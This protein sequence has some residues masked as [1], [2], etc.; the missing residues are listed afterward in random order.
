M[1]R[2]PGPRRA[3]GSL[4]HPG[5]RAEGGPRS[6]W[7]RCAAGGGCAQDGSSAPGGAASAW[8]ALRRGEPTVRL[9]DRRLC[10]RRG[11]CT[12]GRGPVPIREETAPGEGNGVP[13][14]GDLCSGEGTLY[15]GK[16]PLPSTGDTAHREGDLV[17]CRR[18]AASGD[19]DPVS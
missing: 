7:M 18:K 6:S 13:G 11:P 5:R 2:G 4:A 10:P 14:G 3:A 16:G 15:P 1:V 12:P 19:G 8:D 9:S 17:P